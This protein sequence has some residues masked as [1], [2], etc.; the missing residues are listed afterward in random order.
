MDIDAGAI[1]V[2][3]QSQAPAAVAPVFGQIAELHEKRY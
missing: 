3:L 2:Q 1:L